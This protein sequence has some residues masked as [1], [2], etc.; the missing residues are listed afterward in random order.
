[1][2]NFISKLSIR[3]KLILVSAVIVLMALMIHSL[4]IEPYQQNSSRL[5]E[6]IDQAKSDLVWMQEEVQRLPT[7]A[8]TK[9]TISFNGS[10]ANLINRQVASQKLKTFLTQMTPVGQNEI[11]IRYSAIDFNQLVGFIATLRDRGLII[12]DLRINSTSD[13]AKVDS[14]IVF[15]KPT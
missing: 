2:Q 12:K 11:R 3:E 14:T 1:M 5:L 9:A 10:L 8:V 13:I 4:V 7:A 6:E 15:M